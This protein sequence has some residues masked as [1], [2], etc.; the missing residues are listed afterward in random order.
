MDLQGARTLFPVG[1]SQMGSNEVLV[2]VIMSSLLTLPSPGSMQEFLFLPIHTNGMAF[3]T[4]SADRLTRCQSGR[5]VV[6]LSLSICRQSA[7]TCIV[8]GCHLPTTTE[9]AVSLVSLDIM[10]KPICSSYAL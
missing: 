6:M 8:F 5:L 4:S 10:E 3:Q 9:A 2:E 7:V 1:D